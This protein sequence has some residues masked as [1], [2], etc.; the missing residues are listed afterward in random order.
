MSNEERNAAGLTAE[1][2]AIVQARRQHIHDTARCVYCRFPRKQC[3]SM[4][5]RHAERYPDDPT[6]GA[7]I[8]GADGLHMFCRHVEDTNALY[9]LTNEIMAGHVR[10]V[11]E[12]DPPPVLGPARVSLAW[13]LDQDVWWYPKGRPAVRIAS[14]DKPWRLNT[15]R[16]LERR[17]SAI[18]YGPAMRYLHDAPDDVWVS[19]EHEDPLEHLH[20]YPLIKALRRGLPGRPDKLAALEERA[21][22]WNTCP[23]RQAHP[24]I[25]DRCVCITDDAGRTVGATNAVG[26]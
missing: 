20:S 8:C 9:D 14:M 15:L 17:A 24:G 5:A 11:A 16:F 25:R 3:D 1:Q 18:K 13:L 22:H 23:M 7:D 21:R 26:S 4:N 6:N 12:V 19:W 10:T 2:V